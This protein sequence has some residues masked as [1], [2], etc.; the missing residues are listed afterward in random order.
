VRAAITRSVMSTGRMET[1]TY[2]Y[3]SI[4]RQA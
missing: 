2:V 3:Y 1:Y 4:A